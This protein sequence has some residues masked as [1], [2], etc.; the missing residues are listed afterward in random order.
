[1]SI[2]IERYKRKQSCYFENN[3]D[4]KNVSYSNCAQD[5]CLLTHAKTPIRHY[6]Y[7]PLN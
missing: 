4:F 5:I 7:L 6:F 2:K 3:T 1:M